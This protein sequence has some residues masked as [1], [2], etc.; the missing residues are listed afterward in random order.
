MTRFDNLFQQGL[1]GFAEQGRMRSCKQWHAAGP[2]LLQRPDTGAVLVDFSS[3]DYLGLRTHPRLLERAIAWGQA[4]GS[5]SGASRLVTGTPPQTM[6]LEQRLATLKGMEAARIFSSGWQANASVVPA[7]ARFSAQVMGARAVIVADKFIHASLYHGC[8]AAGVTPKRFRH[9]DMAHLDALLAQDAGAGLKIV[10][11]ESVFS[12]D[13]DR[14]DMAQLRAIT[15]RH[16]AFL[17]VDEAHATGILGT[18]GK[19]LAN[20]Q[21]D[22]VVGTFSKTLGGM[23]AFVAASDAVCRWLDNTASGFIYSTAPSAMVLGAVDA[24]LDLLPDMEEARTHVAELA[25]GFRQRMGQAGLE[26]GPSTTQIV[27]VVVGAEQTALALAQAV[28]QAG[29]LAVAIRP[30][31]VPPGGCRLRVVFHAHHTQEQMHALATAIISAAA[32]NGILQE[33]GALG[34]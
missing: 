30:P 23:G 29:F 22:L 13:G 17:C 16:N 26:V 15:Q 21:A 28:E 4:E 9:N 10:L 1:A 32:Q 19:G 5:G 7:L 24:A 33:H 3:N 25:C 31:T 11:T 18:Q 27:P 2:G 6:A 34:A 12:M 8:A 14:A 20:G